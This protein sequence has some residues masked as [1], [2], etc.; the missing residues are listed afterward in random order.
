MYLKLNSWFIPVW[1]LATQLSTYPI[2]ALEPNLHKFAYLLEMVVVY[3]QD[4]FGL[5]VHPNGSTTVYWM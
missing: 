4:Q 1:L 5:I 2:S 3:T